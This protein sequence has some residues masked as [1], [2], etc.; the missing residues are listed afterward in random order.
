MSV[1][2]LLFITHYDAA[3]CQLK[4]LLGLLLTDSWIV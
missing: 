4:S 3:A 1:S 2:V